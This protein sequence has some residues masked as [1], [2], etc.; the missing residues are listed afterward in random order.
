[1]SCGQGGSQLYLRYTHRLSAVEDN[2][3]K[4]SVECTKKLTVVQAVCSDSKNWQL[5]KDL[6]E[7]TDN[8][9]RISEFQSCSLNTT[10][11][12]RNQ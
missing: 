2:D 6:E 8:R 9:E 7:N 5:E 3:Q 10:Y 11:N 1:M 12:D 4:R